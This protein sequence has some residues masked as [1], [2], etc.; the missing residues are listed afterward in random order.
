MPIAPGVTEK[1]G[2]YFLIRHNK[3][4]PLTRVSEGEVALLEA[5]YDLTKADP[6]NMAG[7]LLAFVKKGM[8]KLAPDTQEEYRRIVVSRLIPFC[9]HMPRNSMKQTHVAQYLDARETAGAAVAG[10]RE[11]ACLSSAC[12]Y[13][14]R[15]GFLDF[16]PCHGVRRNRETPSKVYVA[17]NALSEAIDRTNEAMQD[18]LAVAY[19]T[20]IRQT[21]LRL[22]PPGAVKGDRLRFIES[23]TGKPADYEISKTLRFFI[24]R[25]LKRSAKA[26]SAFLFTSPRGLAWSKWGLQSAMRRLKPGFQFRQLRP[27]A[28]TDAPDRNVIGHMGQMRAVYTRQERRRPVK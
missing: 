14:M 22:M 10:N 11:R 4:L 5:Y 12:N 24:D 26:G 2:R 25:A 3:W 13:G 17:H 18:L 19:L 9:G 27:K 16:N 23:K 8:G 15:K 20:G 1:H 7:V 28:Q 21:D 6:H